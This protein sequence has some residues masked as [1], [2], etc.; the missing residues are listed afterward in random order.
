MRDEGERVKKVV[1]TLWFIKIIHTTA[2]WRGE[3]SAGEDI[4]L[5]TVKFHWVDNVPPEVKGWERVWGAI[6]KASAIGV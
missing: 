1:V 4:P 3:L 6:S 5:P 2:Q